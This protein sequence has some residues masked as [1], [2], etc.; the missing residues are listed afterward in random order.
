[1]ESPVRDHRSL[2]RKVLLPAHLQFHTQLQQ[3][4]KLFLTI[5]SKSNLNQA[6]WNTCP[7]Y[8]ISISISVLCPFLCLFQSLMFPRCQRLRAPLTA[9]SPLMKC[10]LDR[11]AQCESSS[12]PRGGIDQ[13]ME[14]ISCDFTYSFRRHLPPSLRSESEVITEN[15]SPTLQWS[16]VQRWDRREV[17]FCRL[18]AG[19]YGE[20]K[21]RWGFVCICAFV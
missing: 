13:K 5:F 14:F 20:K 11:R 6:T 16:A 17:F 18:S 15:L 8:S 2:R 4:H 19:W 1:M 9:P 12:N 21:V 7:R 10:G 3:E